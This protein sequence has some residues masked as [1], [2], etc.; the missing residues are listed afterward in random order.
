[1]QMRAFLASLLLLLVMCADALAWGSE[2]HRIIADIAEQY[3]EPATARQVRDLLAVENAT[4]L[5]EVSNW[6]DEIRPQR[7]ETAPWHF[8]DIPLQASGY[9]AS[10]DC[11]RGACVVAQ[12]DRFVAELRDQHLPPRQRLEA[13]KFVVHFIGDVHQPL[14][15]SDNNDRGGNNVKVLF[16]GR[17]TNLHA[18]WDTWLLAPAVAGDERSYALRLFHSI[19]PAEIAAWRGGS[20]TDWANESHD[21]A[22]RVIYGELPHSGTLPA[23]YEA[24]AL[25]IVNE[26]DWK[27]LA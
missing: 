15:A 16:D 14:H 4:T 24:A 17:A 22:R 26:Q 7:R 6:A 23:S 11:P 3:L 8:V 18:V 20:S 13:L 10:R 5:A 19:T 21:V 2:G 25:P 12:I 1:M 9:D 27:K